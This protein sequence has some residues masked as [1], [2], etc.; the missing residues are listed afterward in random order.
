[1]SIRLFL[2]FL[3][4]ILISLLSLSNA[5]PQDYT[6]SELPDGAVARIGKGGV[7][8]IQYSPDG[9]LLAVA[10][11]ISIWLYDATTLQETDLL[12]E[13]TD[14]ITCMAFSP[15]GRILASGSGDGTVL[16]WELR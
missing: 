10:S 15:D 9:R 11:R 2:T 13:D 8:D 3:T 1:M 14:R 7:G 12:T 4:L 6:Q 5:F 16:L